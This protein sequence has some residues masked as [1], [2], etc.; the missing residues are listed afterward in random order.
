MVF[1]F[2]FRLLLAYA[3]AVLLIHRLTYLPISFGCGPEKLVC[4]C[5]SCWMAWPFCVCVCIC[6][7]SIIHT[8]LF[9]EQHL[10][11][12][13]FKTSMS[14]LLRK[15]LLRGVGMFGERGGGGDDYSVVE[16]TIDGNFKRNRTM[17]KVDKLL[18][19]ETS[20][21]DFKCFCF[22]LCTLDRLSRTCTEES[23]S[24][25]FT[26]VVQSESRLQAKLYV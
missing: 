15:H 8:A 14:L 18:F 4:V 6:P 26:G 9:L 24:D 19:A 11:S 7:L 21:G 22:T 1:F 2:P 20:C 5:V 12:D 16:N 3:V 13:C 23:Y 17:Y 10:W 25:V